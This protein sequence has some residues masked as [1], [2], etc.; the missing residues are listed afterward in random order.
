VLLSTREFNNSPLNDLKARAILSDLLM[1]INNNYPLSNTDATDVFFKITKLF[2]S[3]S[4]ALRQI[5]CLAIKELAHIASDVIIVTSSLTKDMNVDSIFRPNA[6][7]ALCHI[8]DPSMIQA[9]ERFIKQAIVDRSNHVSSAATVCSFRLYNMNKEIVKRWV[10]E[11]NEAL[12]KQSITQYHALGLLHLIKHND[13]M[14][15]IKLIQQ[16]QKLNMRSPHAHILLIRYTF[17][18]IVEDNDYSLIDLLKTYLN[19]RYEMVVFEAAK[20]LC[21]IPNIPQREIANAV[22]ALQLFLVSQKPILRF[23]AIRVL[24]KLALINPMLVSQSNQDIET[25]VADPNRSVAI[26]AITTL[27]KTGTEA[28]VD[29]LMKQIGSFMNDI[30]DELKVHPSTNSS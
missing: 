1:A 30:T 24:N 19:H 28:S 9:I 25:L 13:K 16:C 29:R 18:I 4:P 26:L 7:R 22:S 17:K 12:K 27:L 21:S 5:T 10:N 20:S 2:L 3:K 14:A 15:I 11:L 6:I 8:T 23:A